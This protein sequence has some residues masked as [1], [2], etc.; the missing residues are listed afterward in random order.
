MVKELG[1]TLV[2]LVAFTRSGAQQRTKH[3]LCWP[4]RSFR[5]PRRV[6]SLCQKQLVL[7]VHPLAV[8]KRVTTFAGKL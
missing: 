1:R 5:G 4:E 3:I 6:V 7:N 2:A 8:D